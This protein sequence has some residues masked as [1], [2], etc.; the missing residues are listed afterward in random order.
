M[1]LAAVMAGT[2]TEGF[3]FYGPFNGIET[4][5][6]W[7]GLEYAV[8]LETPQGPKEDYN[9]DHSHILCVG[10]PTNGY[11]FIG[12]FADFDAAADYSNE[13]FSDNP[14]TWIAVLNRPE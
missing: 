7:G 11:K 2:L 1:P 9:A 3:V 6:D 12:P 8:T 10:Q 14:F 5:L 13:H 4:A